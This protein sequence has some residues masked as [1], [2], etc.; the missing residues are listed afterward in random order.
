M[1][2]QLE[3]TDAPDYKMQPLSESK[4]LVL[5]NREEMDDEISRFREDLT[6]VVYLLPFDL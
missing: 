4:K 2:L 1:V 6:I 3:N 5:V